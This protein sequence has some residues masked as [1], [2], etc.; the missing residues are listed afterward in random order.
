MTV[1]Y[2]LRWFL[3]VLCVCF[4]LVEWGLVVG[5]YGFCGV[6]CEVDEVD[7]F[8]LW[9]VFLGVFVLEPFDSVC[10]V[11]GSVGY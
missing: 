3:G 7:V 1:A 5:V 6:W 10:E 9:C 2:A 8:V 4:W 11:D